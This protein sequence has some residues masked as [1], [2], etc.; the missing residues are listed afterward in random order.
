MPTYSPTMAS[1]AVRSLSK[2]FGETIARHP[3]D[4]DI[5]DG[6][7]VE[8]L[9][10]AA[11]DDGVGLAEGEV[12]TGNGLRNMRPRAAAVGG[13]V[14]FTRDAGTTVT[15]ELPLRRLAV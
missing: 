15:L 1:L 11:R 14:C 10:V 9:A 12:P 13:V 8:A 6:E 2:R 7:F 5:A 4:L 3:V